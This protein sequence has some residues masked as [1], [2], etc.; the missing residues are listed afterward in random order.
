MTL[1]FTRDRKMMSVLCSAGR[2]G[3]VIYTKGAPEK[4]LQRCTHALCNAT[5]RVVELGGAIRNAVQDSVGQLT[6]RSLRV[7]A[8][9]Y[10]VVD[11][12]TDSISESD[13]SDF[14]FIGLVGMRDPPRE[15][16]KDAI[17][18]CKTAG[19]R[20]IVVTGDNLET[21]EAIC[22][23][24]GAIDTYEDAR[25]SGKAITG[26]E[27]DHLPHSRRLD[28]C[29]QLAL[30]ARVEPHHKQELV[31]ALKE[32]G[33]VVAMTGDGVNDAPA[34]KKADIGVAMGSGTAVAKYASGMILADDNFSTIVAA[35]AE[36]RAIYNNTKQFIRYMVS[37]NI[38]EVVAIAL[39]AVAQ[40]PEPLVPVQ[41]LW[42][43]LVTDGLPATALGFN[44]SEGDLMLQR[45]RRSQEPIVDSWLFFRYIVVGLYVGFG[46]LYGFIWWF[47][48]FEGG[49]RMGLRDLMSFEH[50]GGSQEQFSCEVFQDRAPLTVAMS[51]LVMVEMFNSLNALSENSSL[52]R[53]PPWS[54]RLLLVAIAISV[55]LHLL[56]LYAPPLA[57]IFFV[58]PLGWPE[59]KVILVISAG[60]IPLDELLKLVT[61]RMR[62]RGGCDFFGRGPVRSNR[63]KQ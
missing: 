43:N 31:G 27:F 58:S 11:R 55:A 6:L 49:P 5:G 44:A 29:T 62:S 45:P 37:S 3:K 38:G 9:A 14:T 7:L 40:M 30:L 16:V 36:G 56:I 41:L 42:V 39:A 48:H 61:R 13:E 21:A 28:L 46:T 24:V 52:L 59:W 15:E 57:S 60:V 26:M 23:H 2:D 53:I 50:C 12:E 25:R 32:R 22:K 54:N 35:V 20:P 63:R 33:E 51:V 34:L 1:E 8:L 19:I 4:V 10:K 17:Q 47:L 18:T